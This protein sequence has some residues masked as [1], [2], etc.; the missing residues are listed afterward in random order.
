[1]IK[2]SP[3]SLKGLLVF[4]ISGKELLLLLLP[5]GLGLHSCQTDI[6]HIIQ[7]DSGKNLPSETMKDAEIM[8]SDSGKVK[9]KL[10]AVQLDRFVGDKEYIEMP[11]GMHILFYDDLMKVSSRLKADY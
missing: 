3:K 1:M 2:K 7:L 9:M 10:M 5:L 11:R 4:L 8:Y 6:Q